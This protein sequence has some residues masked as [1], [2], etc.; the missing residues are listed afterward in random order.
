MRVTWWRSPSSNN[1][2]VNQIFPVPKP[3]ANVKPMVQRCQKSPSD[4]IYSPFRRVRMVPLTN[5]RITRAS[6]MTICNSLVLVFC[7]ALQ[8]RSIHNYSRLLTSRDLAVPPNWKFRRIS[9]TFRISS[10]PKMSSICWRIS[11]NHLRMPKRIPRLQT[12]L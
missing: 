8:S 5:Q 11:K 12:Q 2:H 10:G 7:Q 9:S 4:R 1:W 6:A 3:L